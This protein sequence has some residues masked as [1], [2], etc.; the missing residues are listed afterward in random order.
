MTAQKSAMKRKKK[1]EVLWRGHKEVVEPSGPEFT[2]SHLRERLVLALKKIR[3]SGSF[4]DEEERVCFHPAIYLFLRLIYILIFYIFRFIKLLR[5]R[6]LPRLH[7]HLRQRLFGRKRLNST[8]P[9]LNRCQLVFL[10][11]LQLL[12][13]A[14]SERADQHL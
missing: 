12:V 13:A 14:S 10:V 7:P 3:G 1:C 2:I 11:R 9:L 8:R 4:T 5:R 6:Q